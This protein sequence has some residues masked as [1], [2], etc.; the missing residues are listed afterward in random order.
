MSHPLFYFK[1]SL[2]TVDGIEYGNGDGL[3]RGEA[4]KTAARRALRALLADAA[5]AQIQSNRH[6]YWPDDY[7]ET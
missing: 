4:M 3:R 7:P 2:P 5:R 1:Q 6:R